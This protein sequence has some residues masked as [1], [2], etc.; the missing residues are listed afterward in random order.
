MPRFYALGE[1]GSAI[2]RD[3]TDKCEVVRCKEWYQANVTPVVTAAG[4][5]KT[6]APRDSLT[7][8]TYYIDRPESDVHDYYR[9][10]CRAIEGKET[11]IVTHAQMMR[12]LKVIE[13]AFKSVEQNAPVKVDL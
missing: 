4:L 6:M 7:T 10:F 11:Q 12:V 13:A 1:M 9:N 2:I 8:E 5:T 3:W